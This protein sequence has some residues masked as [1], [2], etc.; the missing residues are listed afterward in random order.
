[1]TVRILPSQRSLPD[2]IARLLPWILA[3]LVVLPARDATLLPDTVRDLA[4]SLRIVDE[5]SFP[6]SGPPINF[7]PRLGPAFPWLQAMPIAFARSIAGVAWFIAAIGALK[8]VLL[9]EM[10]RLWGGPR[11]GTAVALAAALPSVG[12]FHWLVFFHPD[13]VEAGI[14]LA[15]LCALLAARRRSLR[16]WYGSALALGLAVQVHPTAIFY[17]PTLA[18]SLARIRPPGIAWIGHAVGA[19]AAIGAWFVPLLLETHFDQGEAM[20]YTGTLVQGALG[21]FHFRQVLTV[22]ATA[23]FRLPWAVG[24]TYAPFAG[25][26]VAL[27]HVLLVA[28]WSGIVTGAVLVALRGTRSQ[29]INAVVLAAWLLLGWTTATAVRAYTSFYLV[30]FLLPLSALLQG[31]LLAQALGAPWRAF[32]AA[33]AT[34]AGCALVVIASTAFGAWR[35]GNQ[36]FLATR[37]LGFGD[38]RRDTTAMLQARVLGAATRDDLAR[39]FCA[40]GKEVSAHGDLALAW[41]ASTGLDMRMHCGRSDWARVM[42][43][44][45]AWTVIT[46]EEA[47][48]LGR[49]PA[50]IAGN[51]LALFPVKTAVTN[52]EGRP[53]ETAWYQFDEL[54]DPRPMT[55]VD[56]RFATAPGDAVMVFKVK[57][58][59][60][61]DNLRVLRNGQAAVPLQT[62]NAGM[63]YDA[64]ADAAEWRV[65][66]DT[67]APHW[68]DVYVF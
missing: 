63:L 8:I 65:E 39:H 44:T 57:V 33:A 58:L 31:F 22:L 68:L 67:I 2:T 27:W 4:A 66:V 60:P 38:L 55:H 30:Y 50:T 14:A 11:L 20:R 54:H 1:M 34:A 32:R 37:L 59:A 10:G 45:N 9:A 53:I 29:R 51:A 61:W 16:W 46:R 28:A 23:Y 21:Q 24:E 26:P 13:W 40:Q 49:T 17:A 48:R 41:A 15:L 62:T 7:G 43:A 36:D 56:V 3:V 6:M 64:G 47:A 52:P 19:I 5:G 42:G 18:L 12:A 35:A 25:I